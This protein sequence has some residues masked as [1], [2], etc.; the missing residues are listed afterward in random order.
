M[1]TS[2][3]A[4]AQART[5]M[6][7][8]PRRPQLLWQGRDKRRV[9]EAVPAQTLEIVRP[10]RERVA[11]AAHATTPM[12][13]G[14]AQTPRNRLIWTNDNLVAL[15]SL[16]AGDEEH[17]PLEGKVD[18]IY[19]DPP[20]ALQSNF[21]INV[22]IE[23][24]VA[25]EKLPTLIEQLAYEDT[26]KDGLDSYLGMMRDRLELLKRLLAPTGS[27]YVHCDWHA[28]HYL[29]VLMDEVF[30]YVSFV[31]EVVWQRTSAH[32]DPGR[33]GNNADY[34]LVYGQG[35][36]TWNPQY[37][38]LSAD[39]QDSHYRLADEHGRRFRKGDLTAPDHGRSSN[40]YEWHGI[41]PPAGRMWAY[42]REKMQ[43]FEQQGRIIYSR[44]GFP[45]YK[46]YLD[47]MP[48]VPAQSLWTDV[49]AVNP[50]AHERTGFP[51]QKPVALLQRIIAASSNPGGLVLDAFGGSGTTAVAAE[52]MK[53]SDGK[54]APRRWICMD[55]GKFAVHITRKRLIEAQASPFTVENIGFYSRADWQALL[56]KKPAA[57]VY[58]DALV[59]IYGGEVVEG[60]SFLH[61]RKGGH[62][63]HVGPLDAPIAETELPAILAEAAAT[64]LRAVDILSA[65]IPV[66]WNPNKAEYDY[67]VTVH[68]K[69]IPQAAV[70]AVRDRLKRRRKDPDLEPAPEI[71]F[72]SPP[73]VEVAVVPQPGSVTIKLSR[74]TIDLDDCLSTQD[75]AKRAKIRAA[76]TDWTAL[77]DYWGVDWDWED[78]KPFENR[79]QS[80]R[81]RKQRQIALTV[82]HS[83]TT[84]GEKRIAVKVTD[85]FGNDGLKVVRVNV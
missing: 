58:R 70:E 40:K 37:A 28:G 8:T 62:W 30:G 84:R 53:D 81:T 35:A 34:M 61:G 71:H 27:I 11:N 42:S 44:T 67:G 25:D 19:I 65:D 43:E 73:D 39:Y 59:E 83:Y 33:Y 75:E 22:E 78:G 5:T 13:E 63:V 60:F 32:N 6:S 66:D 12:W 77:V 9:A 79:W 10:S 3:L 29:K 17:E 38:A 41:L 21:S 57:R 72:F 47:E 1:T 49:P 76:I 18:L 46:R 68:P 14:D 20:F 74:L 52:T 85:I 55:C 31:N 4:P 56:A 15:T 51:T 7:A 64:D 26:W 23:D 16:L 36:Y 48:G 45:E 24:G 80:F 69:I 82:S 54:P 2:K 50:Q